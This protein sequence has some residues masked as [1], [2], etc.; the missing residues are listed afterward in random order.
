MAAAM[1]SATAERQGRLWGAHAAAWAEQEE[2]G[3]ERGEIALDRVGLAPGASVLEIGCGSGVFLETL[4]RRGA[5]VDG[6]DAAAPLVELARRRVPGA[7]VRVGDMEALPYE[8]DRFDVVYGFNVLPFA[9]D[10]VGALREAGRV[11]RPGAPVLIGVWGRPERCDLLAV[12]GEVRA[13]RGAAAE[14][15]PVPLATPGVLEDLAEAAGLVPEAAFGVPLALVYPD[16]RTALRRL[17]AAGAMVQAAEAFGTAA[18]A[19][20]LRAGLAPYRTPFGCFRLVNEWHH[21]V[22]RA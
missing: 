2:M 14:P 7:E 15:P 9:D 10:V 6:L 17:M 20:A 5:R 4:A 19:G 3:P 21:L 16:E 13:L 11:A 18:V 12:Q 22:A 1:T 8:D